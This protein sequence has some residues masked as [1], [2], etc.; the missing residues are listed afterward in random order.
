MKKND[1]AVIGISII[2]SIIISIGLGK[3][4]FNASSQQKTVEVV[5]T[6]SAN[7]PTNLDK[8][9]FNNQSIDIT[10]FISIGASQNSNP[11]NGQTTSP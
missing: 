3:L 6:I 8:S 4:L 9:Y 7:F 1:L 2:I 10:Q 5:P 11:F